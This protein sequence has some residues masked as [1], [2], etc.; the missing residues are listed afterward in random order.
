MQPQ[1]DHRR[2]V[3]RPSGGGDP[4]GLGARALGEDLPHGCPPADDRI[5]RAVEAARRTSR[6][7][8]ERSEHVRGCLSPGHRPALP[9]LRQRLPVITP[10][11]GASTAGTHVGAQVACE[12][13]RSGGT[14]PEVADPG[15]SAPETVCVRRAEA[16]CS[17]SPVARP[18]RFAQ[19]RLGR[20]AFGRRGDLGGGS[21]HGNYVQRRDQLIEAHR[22]RVLE[23]SVPLLAAVDRI[24]WSSTR[25]VPAKSTL[26]SRGIGR[27]AGLMAS[28]ATPPWRPSSAPFWAWRS[29]ELQL[30]RTWRLDQLARSRRACCRWRRQ[31]WPSRVDRTRFRS[32]CRHRRL[33]ALAS[34]TY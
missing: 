4:L 3:Q 5:R 32:A 10:G 31:A 12:V 23:L 29:E 30:P 16:C 33:A 6:M 28:S 25:S 13:A 9:G 20:R 22:Q 8:K 15:S 21:D 34:R 27:P 19:K 2:G 26:R 14:W 1:P 11:I 17:R 24:R 7:D 18:R